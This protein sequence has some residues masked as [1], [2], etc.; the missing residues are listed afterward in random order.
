M[1]HLLRR[2]I[3]GTTAS[4]LILSLLLLSFPAPNIAFAAQAQTSTQ[5]QPATQAAS[6]SSAPPAS[7]STAPV[8]PQIASATRIFLSNAGSDQIYNEF[9]GGPN[10]A[11]NTLFS[12]LRHWGRFTLVSSPADADL[13]F[14]IRGTLSP[15]A[16]AA[17]DED[18]TLYGYPQLQLRILDPK[19]QTVLWTVT[20]DVRAL[21]R[22]K[23]RGRQFDNS[24]AILV[25]QV[26]QLVGEP[27]T[28][29]EQKEIQSNT[30]MATATKVFI[31]VGIAATVAGIGIMA[32]L[33][34]HRS[35]PT[36]PTLPP[37]TTSP[38]CPA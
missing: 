8:P 19:T 30:R 24:V 38:F 13:I 6:S 2:A 16:A 23:T 37:C 21:G 12:D 5:T 11:Y 17:A 9:T 4:L 18:S 29:K 35:T 14:S 33:F 32:Y 10:R 36:L 3:S 20:S 22:Q 7:H 26:R 31:G 1:L 25:N 15:G 28:A 34:S 27:L